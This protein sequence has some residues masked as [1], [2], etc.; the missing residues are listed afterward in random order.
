M[1][2]IIELDIAQ[3]D[4]VSGGASTVASTVTIGADG[5][6]SG[7]YTFGSKS[8]TFSASL[9]AEV[10]Q[11]AGTFSFSNASGDF[12]FNSSFAS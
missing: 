4:L 9:P 8:G 3:L 2:N 12:N 6:V 7:S 5:A 11:K 10:V 1:N